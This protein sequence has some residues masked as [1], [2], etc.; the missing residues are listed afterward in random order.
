MHA[1]FCR[2]H[3]VALAKEAGIS[4]KGLA[5]LDSAIADAWDA[6]EGERAVDEGRAPGTQG[7]AGHP[8]ENT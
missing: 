6:L 5:Q 8:Q 4:V 1:G 3:G 2:D 7:P